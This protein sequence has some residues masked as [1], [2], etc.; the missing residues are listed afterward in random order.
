MAFQKGLGAVHGLSEPIGAVC[1]TQ[2]GLTNAVLL[3]Y[4]LM[5]NRA[6]VSEKFEALAKQLALPPAPASYTARNPAG[7]APSPGFDSVANWVVELSD[8]LGIPKSLA[9]LGVDHD[10]AA[11]L[12]TK[13]ENNSTGHTNPRQLGA[14]EYGLIFES[15]H[16]G[17][18]P[19]EL[20]A[21]M[22]PGNTTRQS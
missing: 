4:V 13:A 18:L 12:A 17:E 11:D 15:A 16:R 10:L 1:N 22:G 14:R 21:R 2:H 5:A 3:P 19:Q 20:I 7:C 6:H 8:S 9:E